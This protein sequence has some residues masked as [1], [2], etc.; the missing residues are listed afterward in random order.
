MAEEP[1]RK[2]ME[3]VMDQGTLLPEKK[4]KVRISEREF[5]LEPIAKPAVGMETNSI[6]G[7]CNLY[8]L[9]VLRAMVWCEY[10][11]DARSQD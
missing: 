4:I 8:T 1:A 5:R 9:W 3:S 11:V 7:D 2:A 6:G 10:C